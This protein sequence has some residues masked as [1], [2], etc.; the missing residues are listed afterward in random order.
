MGFSIF[1]LLP[2]FQEEMLKWGFWEAKPSVLQ[3]A[4]LSHKNYI[5]SLLALFITSP[6]AVSYLPP[7]QLSRADAFHHWPRQQSLTTFLSSSSRLSEARP[8]KTDMSCER[9]LFISFYSFFFTSKSLKYVSANT[10]VIA[11]VFL[12]LS[13]FLSKAKT[14]THTNENCHR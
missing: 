3:N 11:L 8:T 5:L 13:Q 10:Q 6:P 2:M 12:S 7:F 4:T 9:R 1:W 14:H